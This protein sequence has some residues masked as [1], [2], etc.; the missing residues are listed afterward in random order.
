[1]KRGYQ[2][3][4]IRERERKRENDGERKTCKPCPF[5]KCSDDNEVGIIF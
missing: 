5:A 1:M 4:E 3:K 2:S